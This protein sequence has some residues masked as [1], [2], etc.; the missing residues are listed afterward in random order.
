MDYFISYFA[1]KNKE[2]TV[3]NTIVTRNDRIQDEEDIQDML[4]FIKIENG[5]DHVAIINY[6]RI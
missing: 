1:I 4:K 3:E 2:I 6:R 5:Y